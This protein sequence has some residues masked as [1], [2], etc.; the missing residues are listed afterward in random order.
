M[1]PINKLRDLYPGLPTLHDYLVAG[2]KALIV[3]ALLALGWWLANL[4][5]TKV[6]DHTEIVRE[7]NVPF[8]LVRIGMLAGQIAAI[9]PLA[10]AR[11]TDTR[12]DLLW[13]VFGGLG[14]GVLFNSVIRPIMGT[15]LS[16]VHNAN[17]L[18]STKLAAAIV[19]AAFYVADGLVINGALS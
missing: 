13:L 18:R 8:T 3:V 5:T 4:L 15:L 19:Q 2:G 14:V 6:N 11:S 9:L 10:A 12:S 16:K 1:H 7:N 17:A